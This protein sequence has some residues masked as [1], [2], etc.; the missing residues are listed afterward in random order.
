MKRIGSVV[1]TCTVVACIGAGVALAGN[2]TP[3][4]EQVASKECTNEL[5]AVGIKQFKINHGD[6][7]PKHQH[8]MRNCKGKHENS[9]EN[10]VNNAAQACKAEQADPNF[11]AGHGGL[12][13]DQFYGTNGKPGTNGENK[14]SFGKCVSTKVHEALAQNEAN[15]QNAAQLCRAERADANFS[16]SHGGKSFS[17]FYGTAKSKHKNAF[18]KCVSQKA[19][20]QN[21]PPSV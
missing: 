2:P 16:A 1:L 10:T 18:G 7:T 13:F 19:K 8:A 11:A 9:G 21:N 6:N 12:T 5:H 20:A 4:P 15:L 17:D 3:T 14:N